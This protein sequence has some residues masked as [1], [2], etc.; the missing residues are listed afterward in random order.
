MY[1]PKCQTTYSITKTIIN[2]RNLPVDVDVDANYCPVCGFK[3]KNNN[4]D[5]PEMR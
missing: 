2:L 1:C 4:E 3:V 5:V